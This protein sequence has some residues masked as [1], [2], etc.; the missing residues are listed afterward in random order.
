MGL[1][2]SIA[3]S[4]KF[5][6]LRI[7]KGWVKGNLESTYIFVMLYQNT[8]VHFHISQRTLHFMEETNYELEKC[9]GKVEKQNKNI[10]SKLK[11]FPYVK[12]KN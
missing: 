4:R 9:E 7:F 6:S 2:L 1:I 5:L 11:S 12:I 8:L 3:F 10:D